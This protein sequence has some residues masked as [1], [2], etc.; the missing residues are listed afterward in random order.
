MNSKV[1]FII[2]ED[3]EEDFNE[4]RIEIKKNFGEDAKCIPEEFSLTNYYEP[5]LNLR[6]DDDD[7]EIIKVLHYLDKILNDYE[8]YIKIFIVDLELIRRYKNLGIS[9]I[10]AIQKDYSI[11]NESGNDLFIYTNYQTSLRDDFQEFALNFHDLNVYPKGEGLYDLITGIKNKVKLNE[12]SIEKNNWIVE[13]VEYILYGLS[14]IKAKIGLIANFI[15]VVA[16]MVLSMM[17]IGVSFVKLFYYSYDFF[18]GSNYN[19]FQ[20]IEHLIVYLIPPLVVLSFYSYYKANF[21][22]A[23]IGKRLDLSDSEIKRAKDSIMLI[24]S[25]L[26]TSIL[27][28][29]LLK[30]LGIMFPLDADVVTPDLDAKTLIVYGI[31]LILLMG[32]VILF[33]HHDRNDKK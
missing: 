4:I 1:A 22:R 19:I 27:S 26:M 18:K 16:F 8:E 3:S 32:F 28:Y 7:T 2:I 13:S 20:Y 33:N 29:T 24:K 9:F 21:A 17:A 6:D 11:N 25:L 30:I 10:L 12:K 23:V 31:F 14:Y 5:I 15:I